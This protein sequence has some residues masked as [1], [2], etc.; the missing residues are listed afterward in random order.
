[1]KFEIGDLV[2]IKKKL[3]SYMS[4]FENGIY[5]IITDKGINNDYMTTISGWYP[6]NTLRL[7]KRNPNTKLLKSLEGK[8]K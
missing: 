8:S 5:A 6:E 1:M 2:Y 7:I 4:H 3:P